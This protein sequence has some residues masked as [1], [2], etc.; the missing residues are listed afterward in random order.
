MCKMR[1]LVWRF[2]AITGIAGFP[3]GIA[4]WK[5]S[6]KVSNWNCWLNSGDWLPWGV[7][8]PVVTIFFLL[9]Y[10]PE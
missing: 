2:L 3:S 8:A 4:Q 5:K 7:R 10:S 6:L 1:G 9:L